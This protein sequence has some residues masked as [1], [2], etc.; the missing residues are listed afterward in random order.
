MILNGPQNIGG[1]NKRLF[2][3]CKKPTPFVSVSGDHDGERFAM[4]AI[5]Q[6]IST[7]QTPD[8]GLSN[9]QSSPVA[10]A[11]IFV[12]SLSKNKRDY[13]FLSE[14]AACLECNIA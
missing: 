9:G 6:G 2:A 11:V 5:E 4:D 14:G 13:Y 10:T 7:L 8:L 3:G 12:I 1:G